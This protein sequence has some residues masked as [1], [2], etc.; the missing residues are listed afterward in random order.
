M[1]VACS[2]RNTP[3]PQQPV[4]ARLRGTDASQIVE[5]AVTLP[6]LMV[7]LIGITDFG[8]AFTL[9]QKLNNAVREGARFGANEPTSDLDGTQPVSVDAIANLVG[10][11]LQSAR[12]NDCG[13][14][15]SASRTVQ[16]SVSAPLT[17]T[18]TAN[19]GCAGTL[20][21]TIERGYPVQLQAGTPNYWLIATR[22]TVSYPYQWRF[23]RVIPLLVPGTNYG[24]S[25]IPTEA[26]VPNLT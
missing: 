2:T 11:Y 24:L 1:E 8:G 26:V 25:Q 21:V 12:V 14:S 22:V 16:K 4:L 18:Y 6:L 19:T 3:R 5:F 23:N 7:F 10:H 9:K 20:T 17:W 13:L 15:N